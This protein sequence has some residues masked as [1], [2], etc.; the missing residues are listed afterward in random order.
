MMH[1]A[2]GG[3]AEWAA[4]A[5]RCLSSRTP[6]SHGLRP[7]RPNLR[8]CAAAIG[9]R[10]KASLQGDAHCLSLRDVVVP[11]I[12]GRPPVNFGRWSSLA[13]SAQSDVLTLPIGDGLGRST[14][15]LQAKKN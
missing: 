11:T 9:L 4:R 1:P 2:S 7:R 10:L 5:I 15:V 6:A 13:R 12:G 3:F 8:I 14:V